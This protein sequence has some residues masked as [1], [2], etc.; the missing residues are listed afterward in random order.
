MHSLGG[1]G[2]QL[3]VGQAHNRIR[4]RAQSLIEGLVLCGNV[5]EVG[6]ELEGKQAEMRL[7]N[8]QDSGSLCL[9]PGVVTTPPPPYLPTP[10]TLSSS[11]GQTMSRPL[12][13]PPPLALTLTCRK[14]TLCFI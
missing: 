7:D 11:P 6:F 4:Q 1:E 2:F 12:R 3:T 10:S 5:Q 13:T 9:H 8:K 14:F